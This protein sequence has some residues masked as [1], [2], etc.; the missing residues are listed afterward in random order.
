MKVFEDVTREEAKA[1]FESE[2]GVMLHTG[3]PMGDGPA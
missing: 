1:L 2:E 3:D